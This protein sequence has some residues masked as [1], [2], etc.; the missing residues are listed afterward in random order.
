MNSEEIVLK[1]IQESVSHNEGKPVNILRDTII[2]GVADDLVDR[3][4]NRLE[5]QGRIQIWKRHEYRD[6]GNR[7]MSYYRV[8]LVG[9]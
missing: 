4:I 7:V 1:Y 3:T 2:D 5:A 8:D 6:G 9:E